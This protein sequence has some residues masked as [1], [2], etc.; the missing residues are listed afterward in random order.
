MPLIPWQVQIV[1]YPDSGRGGGQPQA[2]RCLPEQENA[3]P[4]PD[5]KRVD[6][7][8]V[9]F[10]ALLNMVPKL[11]VTPH[12]QGRAYGAVKADLMYFRL[13]DLAVKRLGVGHD[14]P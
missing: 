4:R 10:P 5:V 8:V 13:G 2:G 1:P 9:V 11:L 14:R 7:V 3:I 6:R 12:V